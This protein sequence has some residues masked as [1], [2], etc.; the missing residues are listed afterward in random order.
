VKYTVF[1]AQRTGKIVGVIDC[2]QSK[3]Y[4][5]IDWKSHPYTVDYL[6]DLSITQK[7]LLFG[8]FFLVVIEDF[9]VYSI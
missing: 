5:R 6:E 1:D 2:S 4:R 7:A 3:K 9:S 8:T